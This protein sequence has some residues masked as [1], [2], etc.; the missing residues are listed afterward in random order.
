MIIEVEEF[1]L[2]QSGKRLGSRIE[3]N[4]KNLARLLGYFGVPIVVTPERPVD[5]K[6]SLPEKI[7]KHLSDLAQTFEKAFFDLTKENI[8]RDYLERPGLCNALYMKRSEHKASR[9]P[10]VMR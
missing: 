2:P 4:T 7:S 10:R 1:F 8:I 3:T 9:P 6:G 5:Q